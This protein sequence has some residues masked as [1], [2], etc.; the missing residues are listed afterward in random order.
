MSDKWIFFNMGGA[1]PTPY[2]HQL[3]IARNILLLVVACNSI[4][5]SK[6]GAIILIA[7]LFKF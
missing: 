5:Y 3:Q 4:A 1:H 2:A 7:I 6:T